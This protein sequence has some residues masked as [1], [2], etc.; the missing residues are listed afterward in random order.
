[1]VRLTAAAVLVVAVLAA[2]A[3]AAPSNSGGML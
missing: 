2:I 1:M 3:D